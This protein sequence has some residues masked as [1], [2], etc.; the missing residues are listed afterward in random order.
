MESYIPATTPRKSRLV[1]HQQSFEVR[2]PRKPR[3][4]QTQNSSTTLLL[5]ENEINS[6]LYTPRRCST[7]SKL[8]RPKVPP[9][10]PPPLPIPKLPIGFEYLS[11]YGQQNKL[12]FEN[13]IFNSESDESSYKKSM[14][15]VYT[16][17]KK[18]IL[19]NFSKE[20][21]NQIPKFK[22][23]IKNLLKILVLLVF[24][25]CILFIISFQKHVHNYYQSLVNNSSNSHQN[26]YASD[27]VNRT[28]YF[29]N[30]PYFSY[31]INNL[32]I[33]PLSLLVTLIFSCFGNKRTGCCLRPSLPAHINPFQKRNRFL[34]AAI[35]CILANEIFKLIESSLFHHEKSFNSTE[36][37]FLFL[38]NNSNTRGSDLISVG[39][40]IEPKQQSTNFTSST[41]P[42]I[43][44]G[45][46]T[47]KYLKP[48]LPPRIETQKSL[49]FEVRKKFE[50]L[51]NN[52]LELL[53]M[54]EQALNMTP[55]EIAEKSYNFAL[56]NLPSFKWSLILVKFE[57]LAIMVVEVFI[58][59]MRYYPLLG[60]LDK[61]SKFC[62]FIGSLY[63]WIDL[64][65]NVAV[66][67]LCEGLKLNINFD[68]LLSFQK[69]LIQIRDFHQAKPDNKLLFSTNRI[70]YSVVKCLPHF[71]CLSYVC[72]RL[73]LAFFQAIL[74]RKQQ[75]LTDN[76]ET[77]DFQ[78][79]NPNKWPRKNRFL[80][81][82]SSESIDEKLTFEEKYVQILLA[83]PKFSLKLN[84]NWSEKLSKII[85]N[86]NFRYSTRVICS[87][88]VCFTVLYYLTC[89][90]I[91]YGSIFIDFILLPQLFKQAL[92]VS[93]I[94][95]LLMAFYQLL[96]SLYKFKKHM[97]AMYKG[98]STLN[99]RISNR[100]IALGSFNYAGYLVTYTCWGYLI[101][102]L[103]IFFISFQIT[104]F[105]EYGTSRISLLF[106]AIILPFLIGIILFKLVNRWINSFAARFCFLQQ[107]SNLLALKN[108]RFYSLFLYFKFFYDCFTGIAS[109]VLRLL[110]SIVLGVLFM[111]RMDYSFMGRNLEKYDT[112]FMS[113]IGFLQWEAA[114]TNSIIITFCNLLKKSISK[115]NDV[116]LVRNRVVNKWQLA[117]MLS[118][119]KNLIKYRKKKCFIN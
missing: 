43:V 87:Y 111:S 73:T 58:I 25:S 62:L 107:K 55:S 99:T 33:L 2:T 34:T 60:V 21:L 72:I 119:N 37:M 8:E 27:M 79:I 118:K 106:T 91:F 4:F 68:V 95:S 42:L 65:Y 5:I 56:E 46:V 71:Y 105:I 81:H 12:G 78:F 64:F 18:F 50:K 49:Q 28:I 26:V 74:T 63:M 13:Y 113:Y 1:H 14:I 59:G 38:S 110:K 17:P 45:P 41:K 35:F 66:T 31:Q 24:L 19:K 11:N 86:D 85:K 51:R 54:T 109:C 16:P 75:K 47:L 57:K 92:V 23:N 104:T 84:E 29:C 36:N 52:T 7:I 102:F 48:R 61:Q 89:F 77:N 90:I 96:M 3:K 94:I 97:I 32:A 44:M 101:L 117:L 80:L 83:K 39:F 103:F 114:H 9:P 10:P 116:D 112:A 30:S 70:I 15:T 20:I 115:Q 67:G 82:R 93:S 69:I 100:K 40:G 6:Q 98:K 88:T 53:N 22:W 108:W 76:Y